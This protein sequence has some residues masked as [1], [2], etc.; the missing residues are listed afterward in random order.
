MNALIK[1]RISR[2]TLATLG[3]AAALTIGSHIA[4]SQA[5][6]GDGPPGN[7]PGPGPGQS[8]GPAGRPQQGP[9]GAPGPMRQGP[10]GS[11]QDPGPSRQ[12]PPPPRE[13]VELSGSVISYNFAPRGNVDSL[14]IKT[15]DKTIQ[16]N[17]PPPLAP[18]V[19][20]LATVGN[21]VK[22]TASP[23]MGMPDHGV[24]ELVSLTTE[25]GRQIKQPSPE[26][27]K[28][29][30]E[31][32]TVKAF[33]FARHGEVDGLLLDNGDFVHIGPQAASLKLT[34]SQKLTI[35]G[36]GHPMLGSEHR[37]V[38][39]MAIDGKM[40][41]REWGPNAEGG[42]GPRGQADGPGPEGRRGRGPNGMRG[43]G[44][45]EGPGGPQGPGGRGGREGM[46]GPPQGPGRGPGVGRPGGPGGPDG[47]GPRQNRGQ[48][49]GAQGGGPDGPPGSDGRPGFD[50]P[51]PAEGPNRERPRPPR[52]DDQQPDGQQFEPEQLQID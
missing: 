48:G 9:P 45:F 22:I 20:Q 12:T 35:D 11:R 38:E 18:F 43:G 34:V 21:Q 14:M 50:G 31:E 51:P 17:L 47:P 29:V 33:N 37:A 6:P 49:R 10:G 25:Q 46:D 15:S 3:A 26:D 23:G 19:A 5:R 32:G 28:F 41:E 1:S 4:L 2:L 40:I 13:T 39:A 16:V 7:G 24:Y 30:H 44:G 52:L 36:V 42:P 8:N 27:R